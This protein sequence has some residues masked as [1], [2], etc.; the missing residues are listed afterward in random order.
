MKNRYFTILLSIIIISCLTKQVNPVKPPVIPTD[1]ALCPDAC[2]HLRQLNCEEGN[3]LIMKTGRVVTCEQFCKDTQDTGIWLNP[4]CII[5]ITECDSVEK[6][7][8][9]GKSR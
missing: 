3:D 9:V 1:T 5:N 8:Y 6:V 2:I 4:S 7:C